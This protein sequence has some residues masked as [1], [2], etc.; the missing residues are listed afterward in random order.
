MKDWISK[1]CSTVAEGDACFNWL[2]QVVETTE[3]PVHVPVRDKALGEW[4]PTVLV[5]VPPKLGTFQIM[6]PMPLTYRDFWKLPDA[7]SRAQQDAGRTGP[8]LPD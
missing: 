4:G 7:C 5:G 8:A 1:H 2:E 6:E 3:I